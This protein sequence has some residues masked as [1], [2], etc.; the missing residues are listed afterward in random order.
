MKYARATYILLFGDTREKG[1][2]L[3]Y[4]FSHFYYSIYANYTQNTTDVG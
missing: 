1:V 2:Q 4:A 3:A